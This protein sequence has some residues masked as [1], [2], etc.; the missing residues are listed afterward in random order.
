MP[1][2]RRERAGGC[3]GVLSPV[4][5]PEAPEGAPDHPGREGSGFDRFDQAVDGLIERFRGRP[6]LEA[7]AAVVSNLA[8]YGVVWSLLAALK[9]RRPGE[10][11][12]RALRAL[13]LAGFSSLTVNAAVKATVRRSRP[14]APAGGRAVPVRAPTSSSFPSGHTLAAFCTAVALAD[15]PGE[16]AAYLTFATAVAASRVYLRAHHASDVVGGAVIGVVIG[17]AIGIVGR[18]RL[19]PR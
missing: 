12:R 16:A 11:R 4:G 7:G 14:A 3:R 17:V 9:G 19:R 2:L 13:A 1:R 8:D 6:G 5:A 18:R 10:A 15:S